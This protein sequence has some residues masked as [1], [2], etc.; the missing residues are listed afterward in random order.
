MSRRS[1]EIV[2]T[3]AAIMAVALY[4]LLSSGQALGVSV[5]RPA[6]WVIFWAAVLVSALCVIW[7]I[8]AFVGRPIG[9]KVF[10]RRHRGRRKAPPGTVPQFTGFDESQMRVVCMG[11]KTLLNDLDHFVDQWEKSWGKPPYQL[12][13]VAGYTKIMT[14]PGQYIRDYQENVHST[15]RGFKDAFGLTDPK[16]ASLEK[17]NDPLAARRVANAIRDLMNQAGCANRG[18]I[19]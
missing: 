9:E 13:S 3:A 2:G 7:L 6:L 16:L 17:V 5:P 18:V 4:V 19:T 11:A 10:L 14:W 8:W 1:L 15:Q 12:G